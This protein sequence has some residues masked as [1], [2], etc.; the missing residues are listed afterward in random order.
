VYIHVKRSLAVPMVAGFDAADTDFSCPVRFTTT[1]ANQSLMML[2]SDAINEEARNRAARLTKE[3]PGSVE[4]RV[5][6]ALRLA[7]SR[8][9]QADDVE[10][11]VAFIK[12]L[13]DKH[14]A[15]DDV[16]LHQFALLV[17]NLNEFV[18]LD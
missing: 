15:S 10:R 11:G 7:T 12:T 5:R 4:A 17:L 3:A 8:E 13:K 1:Q 14:K 18:Y 2:N 9:P 6:L 16:A